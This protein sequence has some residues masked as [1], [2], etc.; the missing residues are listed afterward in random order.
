MKA[1]IFQGLMV[2]AIVP[3]LVTAIWGGVVPADWRREPVSQPMLDTLKAERDYVNSLFDNTRFVTLLQDSDGNAVKLEGSDTQFSTAAPGDWRA[4]DTQGQL[5][6]DMR[7]G[8][9]MLNPAGSAEGTFLTL[10]GKGAAEMSVYLM[11][12]G[13]KVGNDRTDV[14]GSFEIKGIDPGVYSLIAMGE[15]GIA[16]FA[17]A[18]VPYQDIEGYEPGLAAHAVPAPHDFVLKTLETGFSSL[19]DS[20]VDEPKYLEMSKPENEGDPVPQQYQG[21]RELLRKL[22]EGQQQQTSL[23]AHPAQINAEK[24][25]WGRI[26]GIERV[27]GRPMVIDEMTVHLMT[28][29]GTVHGSYD[30]DERGVFKFENVE[31]G[32]FGLLGAG[33][34]GFFVV[35]L[36]TENAP[37]AAA[38]NFV[39]EFFV[40]AQGG[41]NTT[42]VSPVTNPDDIQGAVEAQ[43]DGGN[44][45]PAGGQTPAPGQANGSSGGGGGGGGGIG[46]ALG[47]AAIIGAAALSQGN[48]ATSTPDG[49]EG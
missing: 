2:F 41:G 19:R 17:L 13:R 49:P 8:Y 16:I 27:T 14:Y 3:V 10:D 28:P 29:E 7:P 12:S 5:T 45:P 43:G 6:D 22:H 26:I 34:D 31:P 38:A 33:A 46:P 39:N 48:D 36:P 35:G 23:Q 40:G 44:A 15:S 32:N 47:A 30:V 1:R 37:A 9:V 24:V 11:Q 21:L 4:V 18:F 20:A 25:L 42:S